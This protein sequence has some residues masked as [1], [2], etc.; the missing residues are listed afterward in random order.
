MKKEIKIEES[1][2]KA[3]YTELKEFCTF[4]MHKGRESDFIEVT[5]WTNGE[6]FDVHISSGVER[7]SFR[8]TIGQ[9]EALKKLV[10][11]LNI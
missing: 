8:L 6:G 3:L 4:S 11:T 9:F 7:E 5:E 2:R 1:K 10:K